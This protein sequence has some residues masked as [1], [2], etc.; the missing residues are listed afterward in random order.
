VSAPEILIEGLTVRYGAVTALDKISGRFAPGVHAIVGPN[1][2]GKSTLLKAIAGLAAPSEGRIRL[3][4]PAAAHVAYLAQRAEIDRSLPISCA[5]FVLGGLW[6]RLGPWQAAGSTEIDAVLGALAQVGLSD[7]A[8]RLIAALSIGQFQRALF[9]R[10]LL[11]DRPIILLDEPFAGVD[12]QTTDLLLGLLDR[13]RDEGRVV[14]AALHD[15]RQV[16]DHFADCLW[17]DGSVMGWGSTD[18]VLEAAGR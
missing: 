17:L 13:W 7:Q 16:R 4:G 12:P 10:M 9:A 2:A 5:D 15:L 11:Q 14:V 3:P 18:Q 8:G 1:G 6:S